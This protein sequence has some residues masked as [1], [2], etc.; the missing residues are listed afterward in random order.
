MLVAPQCSIWWAIARLHASRSRR[1]VSLILAQSL[2]AAA[3]PSRSAMSLMEWI[4]SASILSGTTPSIFGMAPPRGWPATPTVP[5]IL[6]SVCVVIT[7]FRCATVRC[8]LGRGRRDRWRGRR[9]GR[10]PS[11]CP[12]RRVEKGVPL[13]GIVE[14]TLADHA[15]ALGADGVVDEHGDRA[16]EMWNCSW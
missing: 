12:Q 13:G 10:H 15:G 4:A 2:T 8:L 16:V 14:V 7:G 9:H 6:C 3:S 1:P 11:I 5:C